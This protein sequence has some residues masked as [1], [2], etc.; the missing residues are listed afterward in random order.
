LLKWELFY[1]VIFTSAQEQRIEYRTIITKK[2]SAHE[3]LFTSSYAAGKLWEEFKNRT[4]E[5]W[6]AEAKRDIYERGR[7]DV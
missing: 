2:V 1:D 6:K 7:D 5:H 3:K 4:E